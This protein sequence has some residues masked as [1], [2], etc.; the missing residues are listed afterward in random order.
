M[1]GGT[2]TRF[3]I[4]IAEVAS[5]AKAPEVIDIRDKLSALLQK[6]EFKLITAP[7]TIARVSC[8]SLPRIDSSDNCNR[9]AK[10]LPIRTLDTRATG[11]YAY[12]SDYLLI[13]III[14]T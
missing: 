3:P 8:I 12:I 7:I 1:L 9:S 5:R 2:G 14:Q 13:N 6:I 10:Q 4:L 11:V